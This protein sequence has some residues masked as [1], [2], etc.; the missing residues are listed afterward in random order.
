MLKRG[1]SNFCP[2]IKFSTKAKCYSSSRAPSARLPLEES[3]L[4]ICSGIF[5][6]SLHP[7]SYTSD[8]GVSTPSSSRFHQELHC[9]CNL[10]QCWLTCRRVSQL[11]SMLGARSC[12]GIG[13]VQSVKVYIPESKYSY[14]K[15]LF[16]TSPNL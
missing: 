2:K 15:L 14:Q 5:P 12:R 1:S 4:C 9:R 7:L 6:A 16:L 10:R 13:K 11:L 3:G 8:S